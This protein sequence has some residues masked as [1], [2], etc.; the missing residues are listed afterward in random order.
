MLGRLDYLWSLLH[1]NALGV[2]SSW[3]LCSKNSQVLSALYT[4]FPLLPTFVRPQYINTAARLSLRGIDKALVFLWMV[5]RGFLIH[6][7][8]SCNECKY[9]VG[10]H[11]PASVKTILTT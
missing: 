2:L 4:K 1:G 9:L 3:H 5:A 6:S 11:L 8:L 7:L 10:P